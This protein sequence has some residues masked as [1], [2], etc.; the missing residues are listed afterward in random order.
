LELENRHNQALT[1]AAE[2]ADL[3]AGHDPEVTE[4]WKRLQTIQR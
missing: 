3:D 4:T 1:E 2:A